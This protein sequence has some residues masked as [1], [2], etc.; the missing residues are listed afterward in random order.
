MVSNLASRLL[1]SLAAKG[2]TV[3][4]LLGAMPPVTIKPAPPMARSAKKAASLE[5]PPPAWHD[6]E[7]WGYITTRPG[8]DGRGCAQI[9][10][11]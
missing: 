8:C 2:Y 3:P 1:V 11:S 9:S 4:A 10:H 5:S 7:E 6:K